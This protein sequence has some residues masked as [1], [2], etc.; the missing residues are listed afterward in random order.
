[1]LLSVGSAAA[2]E[3]PPPR[4]TITVMTRN[5]YLGASLDPILHAKSVPEAFGAVAAAWAQVQANDFPQRAGAI[6]AEIARAQPDFVGVQELPLYRM[7]TPSDFQSTPATTVV[8]DYRRALLDALR[9]RKLP[10]RFVA[11]NTNTD[12]EFPSGFPPTMDIRLTMRNAILMRTDRG[13]GLRRAR[14]G[15]YPT[16]YPIFQGLVKAV[17]GWAY[18][19]ATVGGRTF[20]VI[21]THLEAFNRD[22]QEQQSKELLAGPAATK[23]PIVLLGDLNSR[24]DGST[25]ASYPNVLAGGF[26]DTWPQAYPSAI[27]LTC[28]HGDDLRE[29]GG[30]F[31]ERI[32][33]VLERGGFRGVR[34][35]VTGQIASTRTAGG[36]WPSDHGGLWMTLRLP[37][38]RGQAAYAAAQ[39]PYSDI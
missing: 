3:K 6:A 2:A 15:N 39:S 36:L 11:I 28:C 8:L 19:D 34:G 35:A 18:V 1:M 24:P 31:Y 25:T 22:T 33:Y 9:A 20:R 5:L 37:P 13:I 10:Y 26:Q 17:R 21:D 7:Q 27:G 29:P 30:P 32:D 14:A 23:L 38:R 12:V 4:R 16:T